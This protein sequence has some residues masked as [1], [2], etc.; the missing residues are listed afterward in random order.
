MNKAPKCFNCIQL[1]RKSALGGYPLPGEN[2]WCEDC[3]ALMKKA[4]ACQARSEEYQP[5]VAEWV[6]ERMSLSGV[7]PRELEAEFSEIPPRILQCI[8]G[9]VRTSIGDGSISQLRKGFGLGGPI[10]CGK[11]CA[12]SATIKLGLS[13]WAFRNF[14]VWG[15]PIS[16]IPRECPDVLWVDWPDVA[17]HMLRHAIDS[18]CIDELMSKMKKARIVVLDDLGKE[19]LPTMKDPNALPFSQAQLDICIAYRNSQMAPI[20]WT[21]NLSEKD[22]ASIYGPA[23]YTRLI[24]DNPGEWLDNDLDN[25]R[26]R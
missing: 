2:I 4:A 13:E 15:N 5:L 16:S 7:R 22:L 1:R 17:D 24:Q 26:L 10:G 11:S 14:Q 20:F 18:D 8:P 12:V 23:T 3:T 21:T 9:P 6:I 25:L 19:R